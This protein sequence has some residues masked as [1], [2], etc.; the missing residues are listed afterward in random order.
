MFR[1]SM[2]CQEFS[3]R[4]EQELN[5]VERPALNSGRYRARGWGYLLIRGKWGCAAGW[6]RIFPT[7]LTIMGLHF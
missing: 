2:N 4:A 7:G 6:G 1:P 3:K 5:I